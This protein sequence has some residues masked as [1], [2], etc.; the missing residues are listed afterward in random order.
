VTTCASQCERRPLKDSWRSPGLFRDRLRD[1]AREISFQRAR[2]AVCRWSGVRS[3]PWRSCRSRICGARAATHRAGPSGRGTVSSIPRARK[4]SRR[5]SGRGAGVRWRAS[6]CR[7]GLRPEPRGGPARALS[8]FVAALGRHRPSIRAV[9]T[10]ANAPP[11]FDRRSCD[12]PGSRRPAW[13]GALGSVLNA[14]GGALVLG[15]S[16]RDDEAWLARPEWPSVSWTCS[17]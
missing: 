11:I 16:E 14:R 15:E 9:Y 10:Y 5:A 3:G 6:R 17:A 2:A 12:A 13:R 8:A 1:R 7:R 4:A